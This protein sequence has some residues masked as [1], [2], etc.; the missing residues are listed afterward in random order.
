MS[1][2]LPHEVDN[3]LQRSFILF[4]KRLNQVFQLVDPSFWSDLSQVHVGII[5]IKG[6]NRVLHLPHQLFPV[7]ADN[8]TILDC[9]EVEEILLTQ[10]NLQL[11][12]ICL[13]S[14]NSKQAFSLV[15]V[16]VCSEISRQKPKD[17][18]YLL[19][20]DPLELSQLLAKYV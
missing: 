16:R 11:T 5:L 7:V 6:A 20:R 12:D 13:W 9:R 2:H 17:K 1:H 15:I 14:C 3:E 19:S 10:V 18:R 4:W 8:V